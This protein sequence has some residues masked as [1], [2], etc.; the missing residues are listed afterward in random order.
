MYKRRMTSCWKDFPSNEDNEEEWRLI[1]KILNKTV[2]EQIPSSLRIKKEL[3]QNIGH[4]VS[5]FLFSFV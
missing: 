2:I 4:S 1:S 5:H 3:K